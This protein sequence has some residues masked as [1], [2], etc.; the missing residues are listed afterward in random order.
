MNKLLI[1]GFCLVFVA[2]SVKP[3]P[4]QYGVDACYTCKMTL[5][6]N[7]FGAELVTQKGKVYKF[8]DMNCM[9]N[10]YHSKYESSDDL[11]YTLV[12]N[13]DNPGQFIEARH[14]LYAK[15]ANIRTPMASGVAAFEDEM[16][17]DKYNKD[18]KG[19][20]LSWGEVQTQFK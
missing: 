13:Y 17:Y 8:D 9:L 18:W 2:C 11:A 14:A 1:I 5:M 16:S 12:I 19:I 15:S 3:E 10:F 7:K 6:D 20:W 4:L